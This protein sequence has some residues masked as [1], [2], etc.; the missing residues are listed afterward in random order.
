[1]AVEEGKYRNLWTKYLPVLGVLIKNAA[2][3]VQTLQ[4]YKNEF[5]ATGA[6]DLSGY[7]FNL[8]IA[9]GKA[10]NDISGTAVARDLLKVLSENKTSAEILKGRRIKMSMGE[11]FEVSITSLD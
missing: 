3:G 2:K 8:E 1:M 7:S 10:V 6:R 9:N 5:Q 4:L 11:A